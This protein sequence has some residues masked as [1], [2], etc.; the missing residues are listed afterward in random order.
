MHNTTWQT[1]GSTVNEESEGS[2]LPSVIPSRSTSVRKRVPVDILLAVGSFVLLGTGGFS[3]RHQLTERTSALSTQVFNMEREWQ[4]LKGD[5]EDAKRLQA[6]ITESLAQTNRLTKEKSADQWTPALQSI[7]SSAGSGIELRVIHLWK[8]PEDLAGRLLRIEGTVTG[9]APRLDAEGFC[10]RLSKELRLH[11]PMKEEGRVERLEELPAAPSAKPNEHPAAFV[12]MVPVGAP[13]HRRR[14]SQGQRL[15]MASRIKLVLR[16]TCMAGAVLGSAWLFYRSAIAPLQVQEDELVRKQ[17]ELRA[18]LD[19]T[20]EILTSLK[21]SDEKVA[22]ART[23]L[24]RMLGD[25]SRNSMV[26]FPNDMKDYFSRF[27]L[28]APTVRFVTAQDE[29]GLPGYNKLYW[30]IGVPVP[31]TDRNLEGLLRA[32]A[33]LEKEDRFLKM[34]DFALV[35]DATDPNVR[36]ASINLVVLG[37]K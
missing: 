33:A 31:D 10:H 6:H 29:P 9:A 11:F 23:V 35:P 21:D 7:A 34:T 22:E 17:K 26:S 19:S 4:A 16:G 32:T 2:S 36:V 24:N 14:L 12:V 5:R 3:W 30:A 18:E 15:G 28:S 13:P 25:K 8:N 20:H 1:I 37:K 27:A